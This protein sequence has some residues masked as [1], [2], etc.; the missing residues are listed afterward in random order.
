MKW[1]WQVQE[2]E[3]IPPSSHHVL[4]ALADRY[5]E[6]QGGAWPSY[7]D[8]V[9]R[10]G[11]GERTVRRAVDDLESRRLVQREPRIAATGRKVGLFY[12]F[13]RYDSSWASERQGYDF[14][15]H[16]QFDEMAAAAN[17]DD[18]ESIYDGM[19]G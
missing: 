15:V 9:R 12:R 5:N 2:A 6:T 8:L 13:P 16:G 14:D 17:R 1:A 10:T 3:Q 4:L 19:P 11:L 18:I 7:A